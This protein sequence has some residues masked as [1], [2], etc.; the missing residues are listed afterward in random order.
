MIAH[1]LEVCDE[2]AAQ[3]ILRLAGSSRRQMDFFTTSDL[4]RAA[5]ELEIPASAVQQAEQLVRERQSELDDRDEY[6]RA[7][8]KDVCKSTAICVPVL[9]ILIFGHG[10]SFVGHMFGAFKGMV[11]GL[12]AVFFARST[13]HELEFQSWRNKRFYQAEYGTE[14]AQ[15]IL[16]CYFR[17]R[18]TE[19][20]DV[21]VDW[22]VT[23]NGF[24][25]DAAESAVWNLRRLR[26]QLIQSS[27]T[28]GPS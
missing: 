12:G 28:E 15:V 5:A 25:L 18:E 21:L 17:D 22:L 23:V 7:K 13:R 14:D 16:A 3:E 27:I 8:I 1:E 24:E 4:I 2:A 9:L 26:P 10:F 11:K 20:Y 6:R 19:D